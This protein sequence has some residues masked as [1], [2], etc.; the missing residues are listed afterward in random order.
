ANVFVGW[1]IKNP[2]KFFNNF[3][4]GEAS[5]A[6]NILK[7][8]IRS[9]KQAIIGQHAFGDFISTDPGQMKF[10]EIEKA[11]LDQVKPIAEDKYGIEVRFLGLKRI[12][13]PEN[14]TQKVFER[15]TSERQ[16]QI[17]RLKAMGEA[18]ATNILSAAQRDREQLLAAAR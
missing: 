18:E 2:Q 15:M 10:A 7:S 4:S 1:T 5:A 16:A 8:A 13:L 9:T 3:P 6:T 12:G 17:D 11:I 14:V